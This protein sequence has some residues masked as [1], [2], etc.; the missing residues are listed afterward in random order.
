MASKINLLRNKVLPDGVLITSWLEKNGITRS[1][2]SGYVKYGSLDRISTGVYKY[3]ETP[4][5]L[6]G[7][8]S[9]YQTQVGLDYHLGAVTALELNGYSHYVIMGKP[10]AVI[11]TH[12]SSRLPKWILIKELDMSVSEFSTKVFGDTGIEDVKYHNYSLRISSPERAIME[13]ILLSAAQYNLMDVYHLMEMLNS[14]RSS[15]VQRLLEE[16][17]SV[18]VKRL[19]L[20]F[21][22]KTGHRWFTKL[23]LSKISLGSGTR[24]FVKGG[25]KNTK[26]DIMI[27]LELANY[28]GNI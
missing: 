3:P 22:E 25:V 11:F 27:P 8:L 26:Y 2:L 24:A 1:D 14:L 20:Y 16:C 19:F 17:T 28:E 5:T 9:S 7:I 21:A 6:Y 4:L 15:V 12:L 13:C 18:K 23:D 10:K